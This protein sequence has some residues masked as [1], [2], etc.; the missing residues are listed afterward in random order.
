MLYQV[1]APH[2]TAGVVTDDRTNTIIIAAPILAWAKGKPMSELAAWIASK[3]GGQIIQC[4][5]RH[6]E[7][8]GY[9][10]FGEE[11]KPGSSWPRQSDARPE[12]P[13]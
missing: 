8:R 3:R 11:Q 4:D 9:I 2:F 5:E 12:E 10:P 1:R 7:N 13:K 6:V